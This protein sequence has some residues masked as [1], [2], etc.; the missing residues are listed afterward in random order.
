MNLVR[1]PF[2]ECCNVLACGG[3]MDGPTQRR[4]QV[5]TGDGGPV[6]DKRVTWRALLKVSTKRNPQ[7]PA[8]PHLASAVPVQSRW[9]NR[10]APS[11]APSATST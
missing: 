7:P 8:C 4:P 6:A 3:A 9:R 2:R 11:S 10:T 5:E 1:A